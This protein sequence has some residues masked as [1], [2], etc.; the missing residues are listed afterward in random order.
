MPNLS[1]R[2][3]KERTFEA[4]IRQVEWLSRERPLLMLFEDVHWSDPSTRDILDV[5]IQHLGKLRVLIVMTFRPE[6][7][8]PWIG[9]AG[10]TLMTLSRLDR[11]DA[12]SLAA[13]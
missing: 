6:F 10:V 8:P 7:L 5:L 12:T 11:I 2:R 4:L 9:H 1:P 3:R 13:Q